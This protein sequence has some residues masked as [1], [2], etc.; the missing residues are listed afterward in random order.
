MLR[1]CNSAAFFLIAVCVLFIPGC[2][3]EVEYENKAPL[4]GWNISSDNE[5][6]AM[7]VIEVAAS[8]YDINHLE[9]SH[10]LVHNLKD[11]RPTGKA[12]LVNRLAAY[13]HAKGIQEVCVWDHALYDLGYYPDE[14]KI[15]VN[16]RQQLDL[17]NP[18][19]WSWLRSDYNGML[20]LIP[21]VDGVVLTFTDTGA[22]A[23][24][25]YSTQLKSDADKL[26]AVVD[27]LAKIIID[28][29]D[30]SL[31]IRA[32][33]RDQ[34][35]L[36]LLTD[37]MRRLNHPDIKIIA[38]EV[39]QEF[40]LTHPISSVTDSIRR[41]DV[42]IEFD[43]AHEYNGQSI[44]ASMFPE[45]H[46]K[47]WK[48]YMSEPN[49]V[50][51]VARTDRLFDS[52]IVD[53]PCE[54]NLFALKRAAEDPWVDVGTIYREFIVKEYGEQ[55]LPFI[56]PAFRKTYNII[57]SVI[58][59]LG[60]HVAD[61]S[62]ID[63]S[64]E[65]SY[66]SLNPGKWQGDLEYT[67]EHDVN[68]TF[69]Y[70]K[71]VA[72]HLCPAPYKRPDSR[73]AGEVPFV[74]ENGWLEDRELM[75]ME[76]LNDIVAEKDYGVRLAQ[77]A[78]E[79]VIKAKPYIVKAGEYSK[80]IE[81]FRRTEIAARAYRASAKAYFAFRVYSRG[82]EFRTPQLQYMLQEGLDEIVAVSDEIA[83]YPYKGPRADFAFQSLANNAMAI[84]KSIL[85]SGWSGRLTI[86][87]RP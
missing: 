28:E 68:K 29:H 76:Y 39:R 6:G 24:D 11:V 17:D 12:E 36:G 69:H 62:V 86:N 1:A 25:Q 85:D 63:F 4:R 71:D 46:V 7:R 38:K 44:L 57:T 81:T 18:Y 65:S 34:K 72:N 8:E 32:F 22:I 50:G 66:L 2:G 78:L 51:Y 42:V 33:A 61:H 48:E 37:C 20:G 10:Q 60:I 73:L 59:T 79:D 3:G 9:F 75:N 19:F 83:K 16:G 43:A 64:Q 30:L 23:S 26:A 47:R 31:Y 87:A 56:E 45:V 21:H 54:I 40:L 80:L 14:F 84:H 58:Y 5:A 67:V 41:Y 74:F 35:Q 27:S 13:A 15:Q 55:A 53:G 49:V 77:S 82:G 52:R 70:W